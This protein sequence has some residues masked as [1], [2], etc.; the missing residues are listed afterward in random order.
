MPHLFVQPFLLALQQLQLLLEFLHRF[1]EPLAP[2][3]LR[4]HSPLLRVGE[5]ASRGLRWHRRGAGLG[6]AQL[7]RA[8]LVLGPQSFELP[9]QLSCRPLA[10]AR[11]LG[12]FAQGLPP[13]FGV[14]QLLFG[15]AH[16]RAP[17]GLRRLGLRERALGLAGAS[18]AVRREAL[19]AGA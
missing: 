18:R 13:L 11:L 15:I 16:H 2:L 9:L 17:A 10:L 12:L 8:F 19:P 14:L 4:G 7:P 6:L 1:V 5:Q 3:E